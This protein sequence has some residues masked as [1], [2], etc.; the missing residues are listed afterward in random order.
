MTTLDGL[1][2]A[3]ERQRVRSLQGLGA[4]ERGEDPRGAR[5]GARRRQPERRGLLGVGPARRAR[6]RR[7]AARAPRRG[8]RLRRGQRATRG[9]ETFRD[10]DVIATA[11]DPAALARALR[12]PAVGARGRRARRHEGDRRH[13]AGPIASTFGS[14]RPRTT[15]ACCSTS[16][17]R[18]TTTSPSART[19]SGA[20]FSVSEYGVTVVETGEVHTFRDRGR[21]LPL[22]RL[23]LDP[24]RAARERRRA[25]GRARRAAC[26]RSSSSSTSRAS[27]TAT[28]RGRRTARRRSRRWPSRGEGARQPVPR[29]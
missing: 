4:E 18:R 16:R 22:P 6:G 20:G 19:R 13:E 28:R 15:A 12:Q 8:R 3:A 25:R 17:A 9:K 21:A 27:S 5:E 11:T 10:L 23:R 29:A 14:C 1:R 24:A 7:G 2:E 26:R